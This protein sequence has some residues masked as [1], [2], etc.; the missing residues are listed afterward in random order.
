VLGFYGMVF[1]AGPAVNAIIMGL[2]SA[3]F[4][5][6][7]P[8]AAGAVLSLVAWGWAFA[9]RGR[10]ALALEREVHASGD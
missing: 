1:R 5:L 8:V 3:H 2:L 4:G 9:R 6:R 7:L 10:M